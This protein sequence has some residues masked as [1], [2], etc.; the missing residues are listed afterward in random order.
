MTYILIIIGLLF[1]IFVTISIVKPI[2][3]KNSFESSLKEFLNKAYP[4]EY[5]F[6]K[7]NNPLY[8]YDLKIND[9]KFI[10]KTVS[11]PSYAEVQINNKVTWEIKYGAGKTVGKAQPNRKYLSGIAGFMNYQNQDVTKV[12]VL[13][14]ESKQ[15]VMYINECEIEFV[16]PQTNVYGTRIINYH[17]FTLFSNIKNNNK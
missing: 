7:S 17:D 2:K 1:L 12:V 4:N 9:D 3:Q 16:T 8:Q 10:L 6:E 15:T 5:T 13:I 11:I 14:P